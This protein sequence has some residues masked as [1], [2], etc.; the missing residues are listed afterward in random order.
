MRA[1]E[2]AVKWHMPAQGAVGRK[3]VS[4]VWVGAKFGVKLEIREEWLLVRVRERSG[5]VE[6]RG[7]RGE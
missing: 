5:E 4:G 1:E 6:C 7:G 3:K 2:A